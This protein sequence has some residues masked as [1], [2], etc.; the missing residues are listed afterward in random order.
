MVISFSRL[1]DNS[2]KTQI[3]LHAHQLF[4]C[5]SVLKIRKYGQSNL[6]EIFSG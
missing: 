6:D 5:H 1:V 4:S 2:G 3:I